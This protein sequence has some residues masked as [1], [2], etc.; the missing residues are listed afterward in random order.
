MF[1]LG[2]ALIDL[3]TYVR[4]GSCPN[5]A[6]GDFW[7]NLRNRVRVDLQHADVPDHVNECN[8]RLISVIWTVSREVVNSSI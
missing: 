1:T 4:F 7:S 5:Q 3:V 6:L 2:S 8:D